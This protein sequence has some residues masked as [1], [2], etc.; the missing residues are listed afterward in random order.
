LIPSII[1]SNSTAASPGSILLS[2][3]VSC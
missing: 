1:I 3:Q 2:Y